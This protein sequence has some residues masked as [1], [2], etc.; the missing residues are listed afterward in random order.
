MVGY[1]D[2]QENDGR[3]INIMRHRAELLGG[4][5]EIKGS[6]ENGGTLIKCTVPLERVKERIT[7]D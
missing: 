7:R 5:L 4:S 3:G 2:S 6:T 1:D